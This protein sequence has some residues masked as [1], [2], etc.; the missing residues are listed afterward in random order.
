MGRSDLLVLC[1]SLMLIGRMKAIRAS[2]NLE[3]RWIRIRKGGIGREKDV[4]EVP[5]EDD[6]E[7]SPLEVRVLG[8]PANPVAAQNIR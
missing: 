6:V 4:P 1:S 7:S 3:R 8:V 2:K 5:G